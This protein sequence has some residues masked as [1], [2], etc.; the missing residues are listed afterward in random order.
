MNIILFLMLACSLS[1]AQVGINTTDPQATL[2]V[3]GNI[4]VRTIPVSSATS[5]YDFLVIN[6]TNSELQKVN[7][8]LGTTTDSFSGNLAKAVETQGLSLLNGSL[9]A[10]WQK[11]DFGSGHVPINPGG[12][13]DAVT[14][15]YTVPSDGI[16]EINYEMRYGNGVLL[17]LFGT[18]KIGILKHTSGNYEVLDSRIF[19]GANLVVASVTISNT[20]INSVYKLTAGDQLSFEFFAGSIGLGALS[21]SYASVVVKKISN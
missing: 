9:F 17:G 18:P 5:T 6:P 7:G 2:D 20:A 19:G 12:H 8:S 13:F 4:M 3:N 14:D 15:F 21:S 10:G 1:N 16:Y 11:I